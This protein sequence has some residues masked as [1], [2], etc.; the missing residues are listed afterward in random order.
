MV[1]PTCPPHG[2]H[3]GRGSSRAT[4]GIAGASGCVRTSSSTRVEGGRVALRRSVGQEAYCE[5]HSTE[6]DHRQGARAGR[7][8]QGSPI[9]PE[10]NSGPRGV[11]PSTVNK[12]SAKVSR[13]RH[14]PKSTS[15]DSAKR[16]PAR[17]APESPAKRAQRRGAPAR[18]AKRTQREE[19][20][21]RQSRNTEDYSSAA[22]A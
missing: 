9:K 1:G 4:A 5:K 17:G 22:R 2:R 21:N 3:D 11:S 20:Q 18:H 14:R 19:H 16:S 8:P 6:E 10:G 15:E 7:L 13:A 12:I